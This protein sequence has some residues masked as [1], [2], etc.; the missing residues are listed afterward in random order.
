M[1][2]HFCPDGEF[3]Q[4]DAQDLPFEDATFDAIVAA[5]LFCF[6]G[7]VDQALLEAAR[8]LKPG[9]RIVVLDT[10]WDSLIWRN[11]NPELMARMLAAYKAVYADAHLPK[12][13]RQRLIKTGFSKID[14][15]SFVVLNT[16]FRDDTYARQTAGFAIS[17]MDGSQEFSAAEKTSWLADLELLDQNGGFFFSLNRYIFTGRK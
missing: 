9:G 15:D 14:V 6:L 7:D 5:Q 17:I 8:V 4:G 11:N 12:S 10:D 13:L 3:V 2:R 16:G 1:A